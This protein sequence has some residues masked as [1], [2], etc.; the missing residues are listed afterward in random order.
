MV[1]IATR[2][3]SSHSAFDDD[4]VVFSLSLSLARGRRLSLQSDFKDDLKKKTNTTTTT[5]ER[6]P[7]RRFRR[8]RRTENVY[9]WQLTE[10]DGVWDRIEELEL[11]EEQRLEREQ[12]ISLF[13]T[14]GR[15]KRE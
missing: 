12:A 1:T 4:D 11:L 7:I 2:R 3:L 8:R 13:P 6:K 5:K 9:F 14:G 10:T 15:A